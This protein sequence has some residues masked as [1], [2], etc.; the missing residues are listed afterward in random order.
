[1]NRV[2]PDGRDYYILTNDGRMVLALKNDDKNDK[3]F[4][5]KKTKESNEYTDIA[6]SIS[7][8][9]GILSQLS[10]NGIGETKNS[11]DAFSLYSFFV[12]NSNVEWGL[13]G[14]R[15]GKQ[16]NYVLN[17]DYKETETSYRR[18]GNKENNL[19]FYVHSH[20]GNTES[21]KNAS[22]YELYRAGL[23]LGDS[24]AELMKVRFNAAKEA[25][26]KWPIDYPKLFFYHKETQMLYHFNHNTSSLR[27]GEAS[28]PILLRTL[29]FNFKMKP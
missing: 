17:T 21:S 1:M 11:N 10:Q 19:L 15:S 27:V 9:K 8:N 4:A 7:V 12:G 14:F 29:I 6:N 20:P 2:D 23:S 18:N 22:G 16:I 24:D 26:R 25:N 3:L 5:L 28:T 13:A